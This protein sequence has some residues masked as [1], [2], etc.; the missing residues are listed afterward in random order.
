[1]TDDSIRPESPA[2]GKA[3]MRRK[4]S[5]GFPVVSLD[6]AAAILREAGKYGFEHSTG[7]FAAIMGHSTTN[8]G[9]FRQ[10]LAAM[11]D[12][13]L[14]TGRGDNV[15]M[16]D[17]ARVI[18]L[19]QDEAAEKAALQSAF[20]SCT[21]FYRLYEDSTKVTPLPR[22]GL[23][24]RAVHTLGVA[25]GSASKFVAS[26]VASAAVAG[27]AE[28]QGDGSV[29]LLSSNEANRESRLE[30]ESPSPEATAP[31]AAHA[32]PP[33]EVT[34]VVHQAWQISGG[35]V[36]FEIYSERPLPASAFPTVGEVVMTLE[37][38]SQ[39]LTD[40]GSEHRGHG[41]T[42]GG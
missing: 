39:A 19:P 3:S 17:I 34:P 38:L 29:I 12:W 37:R 40:P 1:M 41:V 23:G 25:P 5:T 35:Q 21:V 42:A 31:R 26:F 32:S 7:E 4:P 16:T 18:A 11:R 33:A 30:Q 6:E 22:P 13:K 10:R 28:E 24:A 14:I 27:L 20:A 36:V 8:S 15:A 2:N 9:A